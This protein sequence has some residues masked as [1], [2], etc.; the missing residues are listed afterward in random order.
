ML[1][2]SEAQRE[3]CGYSVVVLGDWFSVK[4]EP[5]AGARLCQVLTG[6]VKDLDSRSGQTLKGFNLDVK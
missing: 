2:S 6:C 3:Q 5:W 1:A 4:L